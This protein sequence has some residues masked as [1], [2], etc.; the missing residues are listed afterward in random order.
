MEDFQKEFLH[1]KGMINQKHRLFLGNEEFFKLNITEDLRDKIKR[2]WNSATVEQQVALFLDNNSWGSQLVTSAM[3]SFGTE[4]FSAK[5]NTANLSP[6]DKAIAEKTYFSC[7]EMPGFEG[8]IAMTQLFCNGRESNGAFRMHNF[9][10]LLPDERFSSHISPDDQRIGDLLG[11]LDTD[12]G[13][14]DAMFCLKLLKEVYSEVKLKYFKMGVFLGD[15]LPDNLWSAWRYMNCREFTLQ[16]TTVIPLSMYT[17]FLD[18]ALEYFRK[19]LMKLQP[20]LLTEL[21]KTN[22]AIAVFSTLFENNLLLSFFQNNPKFATKYGF[23][24]A[25]MP[26]QLSNTSKQER[27]P[28]GSADGSHSS[29]SYMSASSSSCSNQ[30]NSLNNSQR[31]NKVSHQSGGLS[32]KKVVAKPQ[33]M[34]MPEMALYPPHSTT[35]SQGD[36]EAECHR[37]G[38]EFF[39]FCAQDS[40]GMIY[41]PKMFAFDQSA[42]FGRSLVARVPGC[43]IPIPHAQDRLE[44]TI[45]P[46][47]PINPTEADWLPYHVRRYY[48]V[49]EH[50][51]HYSPDQVGSGEDLLMDA[52]KTATKWSNASRTT[53]QKTASVGE[54]GT[55][56]DTGPLIASSGVLQSQSSLRNGISS[57][58]PRDYATNETIPDA[59]SSRGAYEDRRRKKTGQQDDHYHHSQQ[60]FPFEFNDAP[61]EFAP[62][63]QS[64]VLKMMPKYLNLQVF[65]TSQLPKIETES[66]PPRFRNRQQPNQPTTPEEQRQYHYY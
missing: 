31:G 7:E 4:Y 53:Q 35:W 2:F 12:T 54:E 56:F 32:L 36:A 24:P 45:R 46:T 8:K 15:Y 61:R 51:K 9:F 50:L 27:V 66:I 28:H 49:R 47:P 18:N 21:W 58:Q 57:I 59:H 34:M 5:K 11:N 1:I 19:F 13:S 64:G 23:T 14:K 42:Q 6:I 63:I 62:L 20:S 43:H 60:V 25:C 10:F 17:K 38:R 3:R 16:E 26:K 29:N 33:V 65:G 39:K 55:R 30:S 44:F 22:I 41:E 52:M 37:W 40:S 48:I